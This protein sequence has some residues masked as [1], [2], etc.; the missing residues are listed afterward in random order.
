MQSTSST[1]NSHLAHLA[2]P[3]HVFKNSKRE[4]QASRSIAPFPPAS[5]GNTQTRSPS[6]P[7]YIPAAPEVLCQYPSDGERHSCRRR[8]LP[9]GA[10]RAAGAPVP[11]VGG[12]LRGGTLRLPNRRPPRERGHRPAQGPAH[13]VPNS[14]IRR[15]V[16]VLCCST[17]FPQSRA[18]CEKNATLIVHVPRLILSV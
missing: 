2:V 5:Q 12:R 7:L 11:P 16:P 1:A 6:S 4:P 17:C 3:P 14:R 13:Q 10:C 9:A 8:H 18:P 15:A